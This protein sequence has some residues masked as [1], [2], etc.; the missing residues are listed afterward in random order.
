MADVANAA[1]YGEVTATIWLFKGED[2]FF[3]TC[4]K[5]NSVLNTDYLGTG[6]TDEISNFCAIKTLW[7]TYPKYD[8]VKIIL[9]PLECA[10]LP[11][12]LDSENTL[13]AQQECKAA[14]SSEK[15]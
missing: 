4:T 3:F 6:S 1:N 12:G 10:S 13:I 11:V 14:G 2:H 9:K 7:P 8:N 15:P 5:Y